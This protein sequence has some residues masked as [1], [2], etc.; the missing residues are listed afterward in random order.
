[1]KIEK[2]I[3]IMSLFPTEITKLFDETFNTFKSYEQE[4]PEK[5]IENLKDKI[6]A[7]AVMGGTKVSSELIKK[8][9]N[10]KIIANYGVGYDA[11][12]VEQATLHNVKVTNTPNVL[13]DEVADTAVALTLCVYKNISSANNFLLKKKWL[14]SEFPLSKKFSGT[15]FGILGMGRIGK[16]IAKRIEA[17]NCEICYHSRNEKDVKYKYFSKLEE[18]AEYVD[19]LCVITPGGEETKHLVNSNIL[20]K[21]G[22]NGFLI[23]IA[24]GSVIDQQALIHALQNKIICGAGLDVF[25]NEPN[26]PDDLM[27]LDNV[28]LTPHI[29]S[30]TVETRYDMGKLVYD[31][32]VQ[33]LTENSTIS[34]VN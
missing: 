33:M 28:I 21:L 26:V 25:E 34:P 14:K 27:N 2:N 31:N 23:N 11:V 6:D 17:F 8:L 10:L 5:F 18:L 12:D 7:I 29:G 9:P 24:R 1:M 22:K 32:V 15:K 19:T 13:N 3:L 30:A 4:N 16:T 20:Q